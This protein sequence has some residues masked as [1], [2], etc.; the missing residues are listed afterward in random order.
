MTEEEG[1]PPSAKPPIEVPSP[2]PELLCWFPRLLEVLEN[3]PTESKMNQACQVG[4]IGRG[5]FIILSLSVLL[6][7][8]LLLS[9]WRRRGRSG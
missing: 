7:S 4:P 9:I 5:T 2:F 8:L 6:R 3:S 1:E